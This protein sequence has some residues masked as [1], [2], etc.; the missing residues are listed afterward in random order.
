M[1]VTNGKPGTRAE[2]AALS[3]AAKFCAKEDLP[4]AAD[5]K[6]LYDKLTTPFKPRKEGPDLLAA[7]AILVAVGDGRII[8]VLGA[9]TAWWQTLSNRCVD[10][11]V[12]PE[13]VRLVGA[14]LA[15]QPW[16]N[17]MTIDRVMSGWP[18]YLARAKKEP[19]GAPTQRV[20]SD[21]EPDPS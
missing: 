11:E 21:Y 15:Q 20:R 9:N 5:L 17:G 12:T 10:R 13:N 7:Q 2:L 14:W 4:F 1:V 19:N 3:A 6:T 8:E 18:S 16:V